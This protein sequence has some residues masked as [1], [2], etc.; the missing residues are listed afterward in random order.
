MGDFFYV[1]FILFDYSYSRKC[2]SYLNEKDVLLFLHA[3]D[4]YT[5]ILW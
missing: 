1:Y 4:V 5:R 2:K 3:V